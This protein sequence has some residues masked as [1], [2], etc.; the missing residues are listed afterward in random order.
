MG[1]NASSSLDAKKMSGKKLNCNNIPST[2]IVHRRDEVLKNV[3]IKLLL[4]SV[5]FY[6]ILFYII[7]CITFY[8]G[9]Q[10]YFI[11]SQR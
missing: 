5:L 10:F 8:W 6:C 7:L 4:F 9:L 2:T 11:L 3:T 1:I